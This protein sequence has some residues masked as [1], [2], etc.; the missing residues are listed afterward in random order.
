[1]DSPL[2]ALCTTWVRASLA[3]HFCFSNTLPESPPAGTRTRYEYGSTECTGGRPRARS[4]NAS[5]AQRGSLPGNEG[6]SGRSFAQ[7]KRGARFF[8]VCARVF[9]TKGGG[10]SMRA[11]VC[12]S[13]LSR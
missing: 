13:Y 2:S 1:M 8:C 3:G 7:E 10:F 12:A 6:S 5:P 11:M 4:A 9:A